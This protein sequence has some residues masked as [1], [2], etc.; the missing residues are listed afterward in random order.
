MSAQM[1]IWEAEEIQEHSFDR[2]IKRI[3]L[4]KLT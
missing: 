4:D 3:T 1:S 2:N